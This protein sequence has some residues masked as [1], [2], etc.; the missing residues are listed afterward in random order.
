MT[1][2]VDLKRLLE[3]NTKDT[4]ARVDLKGLFEPET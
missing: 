4:T 3:P 2:R 1:T